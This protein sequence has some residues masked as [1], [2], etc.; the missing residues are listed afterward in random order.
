MCI[1]QKIVNFFA[2]S[3]FLV[4]CIMTLS[5]LGFGYFSINLFLLFK[6]NIGLINEFGLLALQEG[7]AMQLVILL[8]E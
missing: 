4:L 1:Q 6:A 3:P 7:A 2:R 8:A 5:F